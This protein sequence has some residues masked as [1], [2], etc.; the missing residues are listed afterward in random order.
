VTKQGRRPS[1]PA[2]EKDA[3]MGSVKF[4]LAAVAATFTTSAV[5]AADMPPLAPPPM[6]PPP[7]EDFSNWY[8]RG[9]IGMSNQKV[10]KMYNVLYDTTANLQQIDFAFD[11]G[12]IY[13]AG[14]GYQWNNWLR[15]DVT[16]QY[17][18][19]TTF[20][21]FEYVP[22]SGT[23]EYKAIKSEWVVLANLYAD[24]GTW[25]CLTPF[26]GVGVGVSRNTISNFLDINTVTQGVAFG[27]EAS[28]WNF[29]WAAHAG[30]AYRVTPGFTI[31]LA[32]SY[33]SLGDAKS[34]D[35]ITWDGT[36]NVNNPMHFKDIISHDLKFGVR[37][38]M[39]P[40]QMPALLMPAPVMRRG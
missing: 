5:F 29:A 11:S 39:E 3:A 19:G 15:F 1:G 40:E 6:Q 26:V 35:L 21:G 14:V 7:P 16:A 24:L 9:D 28:V 2:Q 10:G 4:V 32:Y 38:M 17:R 34:G 8:L 31:E 37:W 36:N 20:H 25:W 18:G 33:M 12:V 30:V 13:G 23:D 27:R 22:G